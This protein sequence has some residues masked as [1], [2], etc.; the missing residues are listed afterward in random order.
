MTATLLM[1]PSHVAADPIRWHETRK[2]GITASEIGLVM[3]ISPYGGPW[4]L[5]HQ[6]IRGQETEDRDEMRR[7]RIVEPYAL[8]R[9]AED[10]PGFVLLPGGLYADSDR[11]WMMATFDAQ[12]CDEDT[13]ANLNWLTPDVFRADPGADIYPVQ[14]KSTIPVAEWGWREDTDIMP[15]HYRAQV[16]WE[17]H[18]RRAR[19]G[20]VPVLFMTTWTVKTY[21]IE[22]G[23]REQAE[24]GWMITEAERFLQRLADRD[25]PPVDWRPETTTLLRKLYPGIED[26]PVFVPVKI[27]RRYRAAL[28]A[29]RRAERRKTLA[30]NQMLDRAGPAGTIV[31]RDGG[32][33][34][35]VATRTAGPMPE[36]TL[37]AIERV[38]RFNPCG[39][40]KGGGR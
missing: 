38:D 3:D 16:L 8:E 17:M 14:A 39:W 37:K 21:L 36:R 15:A 25:A 23:D 6:K 22:M 12:C 28:A 32:R 30:V 20:F 24:I 7:G 5:Y 33:T 1:P 31:T 19:F 34:I 35:K 4:K 11:P 26:R 2:S 9:F 10:H 40:A 18:I 13:A 27:A 29:V